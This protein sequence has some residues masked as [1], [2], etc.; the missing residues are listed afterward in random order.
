MQILVTNLD[1]IFTYNHHHHHHHLGHNITGLV[2]HDN[3]MTLTQMNVL[4]LTLFRKTGAEFTVNLCRAA[5]NSQVDPSWIFKI[6]SQVFHSL[7]I[8]NVKE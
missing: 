5:D 6:S 4:F 3:F 1:L 8:K 7:R 2:H